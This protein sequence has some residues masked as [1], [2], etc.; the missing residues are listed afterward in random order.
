MYYQKNQHIVIA[1]KKE[2]ESALFL[3]MW[4]EERHAYIFS[5]YPFI[6]INYMSSIG[7]HTRQPI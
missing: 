2:L 6:L 7:P 3:F 1:N 5:F 4:R